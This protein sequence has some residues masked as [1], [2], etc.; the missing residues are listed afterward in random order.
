MRLKG[1]PKES[2]KERKQRKKEFAETKRQVL[3]IALPTLVVV[4]IFIVAYVYV[5]TR[6]KVTFD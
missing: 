4:F 3:T 5:K 2:S 1:K 6:P